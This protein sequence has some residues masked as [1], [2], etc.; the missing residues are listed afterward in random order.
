[1][2]RSK[3]IQWF[4]ESCLPPAF[5]EEI[6]KRGLQ[7]Q[8]DNRNMPV[9]VWKVK[10]MFEADLGDGRMIQTVKLIGHLKAEGFKVFKGKTWQFV[11]FRNS[12][13][14]RNMEI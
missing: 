12:Q 3:A 8:A 10:E 11:D 2:S 4:N 13:L 6:M 1:M 7:M 9:P 5:T 14:H